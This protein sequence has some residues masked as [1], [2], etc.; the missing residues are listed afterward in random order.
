MGAHRC[1]ECNLRTGR[2]D[3]HPTCNGHPTEWEVCTCG[4]GAHPRRCDLHPTRYDEHI[5]EL[6]AED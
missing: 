6:E 5:A 1:L 2:P 4:S 3:L